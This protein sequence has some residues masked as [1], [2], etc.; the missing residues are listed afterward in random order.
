MNA[1]YSSSEVDEN[2]KSALALATLFF[3]FTF[4][5]AAALTLSVA[6]LRIILA[7]TGFTEILKVIQGVH[8]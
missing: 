6:A 7:F 1:A 2:V 3:V 4:A 8:L 5:T